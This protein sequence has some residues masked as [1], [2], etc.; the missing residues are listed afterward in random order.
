[1]GLRSIV[2]MVALPLLLVVAGALLL[3]PR[4]IL[5]QP[6]LPAA[7][8]AVEA[9]PDY[10]FSVRPRPK[11]AVVEFDEAELAPP[12]LVV[13]ASPVEP[14]RQGEAAA[15]RDARD[16]RWITARGLNVRTG[17]SVRDELI[18][19]LPFGTPVEVLDTSGTWAHVRAGDIIGWLSANFLTNTDP[20]AN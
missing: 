2:L 12:A 13:V 17:P 9:V 11:I 5:R 1:M 19:S 16:L 4:D 15:E 20:A 8:A 10:T 18:A 7:T 14:V 6:V 3:I